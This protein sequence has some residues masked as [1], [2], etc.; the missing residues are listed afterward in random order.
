MYRNELL[1]STLMKEY[2]RNKIE[3]N[4]KYQYTP[5][6]I[7]THLFSNIKYRMAISVFSFERTYKDNIWINNFKIWSSNFYR[8]F[9]YRC[10]RFSCHRYC[11]VLIQQLQFVLVRKQHHLLFLLL[12]KFQFLLLKL[13]LWNKGLPRIF[14]TDLWTSRNR[15]CLEVWTPLLFAYQGETQ[16]HFQVVFLLLL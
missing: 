13:T 4:M 14:Q 7:Y 3:G 11:L 2:V 8:V 16:Q 1:Y 12:R 9:T 15:D 6:N 10:W 5:I